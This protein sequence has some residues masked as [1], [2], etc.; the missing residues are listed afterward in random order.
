MGNWLTGQLLFTDESRFTVSTNDGRRRVWRRRRERYAAC[1]R[2]QV[3][4]YGGGSVMVWAGICL[5][6]RTDLHVFQNGGIT[7]QRYRDEILE[8]I[9]RP[10]A[11]A[12]GAG[13]ILMQDNARPHTA[14]LSM[15]FLDSEGIDVMEWPARSPDLNPIEHCWDMLGRRTRSKNPPPRTMNELRD[16]LVQ[17][18]AVMPQEDIDRVVRS[19]HNRCNECVNARGGHTSY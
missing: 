7:A 9:V 19:M 8:P 2:V 4:A 5:G 6:S 1:N 15:A 13:F 11:A 12:M 18:W 3:D 10:F 17:Q 16:A 14:R